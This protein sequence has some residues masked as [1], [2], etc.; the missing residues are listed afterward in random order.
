MFSLEKFMFAED[1]LYEHVW[2]DIESKEALRVKVEINCFINAYESKQEYNTS[3]LRKLIDLITNR[4]LGK[5]KQKA[6]EAYQENLAQ[7]LRDG[8][9][10]AHKLTAVDHALPSLRLIFEEKKQ[11]RSNRPGITPRIQLT[12]RPPNRKQTLPG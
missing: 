5:G 11:R 1:D 7:A 2:K 9:G 10:P 6:K 4:S 12:G 3:D 8:A